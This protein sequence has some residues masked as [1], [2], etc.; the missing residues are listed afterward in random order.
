MYCYSF[1]LLLGGFVQTDVANMV[2]SASYAVLTVT[3]CCSE[4]CVLPE[5]DFKAAGSS[6]LII[7][8]QIIWFESIES[9]WAKY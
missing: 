2:H 5:L 1:V 9:P 3:W 6:V 7:V 8:C 4:C